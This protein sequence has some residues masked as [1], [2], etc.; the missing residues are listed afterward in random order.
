MVQ[1]LDL[2]NINTGLLNTNSGGIQVVQGTLNI[3]GTSTGVPVTGATVAASTTVT[4]PDTTGITVGMLV[5]GAGIPSGATVVS[6]TNGTQFVISAAATVQT[7]TVTLAFYDPAT[8]NTFASGNPNILANTSVIGATTART[9]GGIGSGDLT[10]YSGTTNI[11]M[12]VGAGANDTTRQRFWVGSNATGNSLIVNGGSTLTVDRNT[13]SGRHQQAPGLHGSDHRQFTTLTSTSGSYVLEINGATNLTGTPVLNHTGGTLLLNGAIS[14]GGSDQA[15]I[16]GGGGD[17]WIND[18]TSSFGGLFA[19]TA[20]ANG[21]GIVVNGGL[22]RFGDVATEN[23][24]AMNL[25]AILR[26]STIRINP[27]GNIYITNPA[28]INFGTGQVELLGS[29]PQL[30]GLPHGQQRLHA[31]LCA[32]RAQLELQRCAWLGCK[33][34]Q[35]V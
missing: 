8:L 19:G 26:G 24:T 25:S 29:G 3:R 33:H 31:G 23:A 30:S 13:T 6:I 17:L 27:T 5:S 12:D 15:I 32:E 20:G 35:C 1:T 4:V 7:G 16:K 28:N 18:A 9:N 14:D 34:G 21:L 11:R 10:L 2:N 22:L